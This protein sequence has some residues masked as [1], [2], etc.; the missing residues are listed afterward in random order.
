MFQRISS[1]LFGGAEDSSKD[2]KGPKPSVLEADEE[3]W[4]LVSMPEGATIT[5]TS[6]LEDILMDLPSLSVYG[7]NGDQ[8]ATEEGVASLVSIASSVRVLE[9]PAPRVRSGVLGRVTRGTGSQAGAL[10]KVTQVGRVQRAQA[11]PD[12][13]RLGRNRAGHQNA[14][15]N[16]PP[17]SAGRGHGTFL[18]Q[19]GLRACN[20]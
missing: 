7:S 9:Q 3:G 10:A 14:A 15:R 6:P 18:H 2:L 8:A 20:H 11:R 4:L 19:P 1:L 17:R 12:G 5:D 13:R 16:H